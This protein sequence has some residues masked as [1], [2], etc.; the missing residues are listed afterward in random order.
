MIKFTQL[1]SSVPNE[2]PSANKPAHR[3][4]RRN[5]VLDVD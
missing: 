5:L 4:Y 3:L 1:K 2:H